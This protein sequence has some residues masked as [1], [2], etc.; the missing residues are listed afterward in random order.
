MEH[1]SKGFRDNLLVG[2]KNEAT[3][4]QTKDAAVIRTETPL[5]VTTRQAGFGIVHMHSSTNVT[6]RAEQLYDQDRVL[7]PHIIE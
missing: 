4:V 2:V 7:P 6:T 5:T 1:L 3:A